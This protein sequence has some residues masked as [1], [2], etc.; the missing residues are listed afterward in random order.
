MFRAGIDM[1]QGQSLSTQ[2]KFLCQRVSV[3]CL[4]ECQMIVIFLLQHH[5]L[6]LFPLPTPYHRSRRIPGSNNHVLISLQPD[7]PP[8][9]SSHAHHTADAPYHRSRNGPLPSPLPQRLS[10]QHGPQTRSRAY[11]QRECQEEVPTPAYMPQ[12]P[13]E[14]WK[15]PEYLDTKKS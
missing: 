15:E 9:A 14:H 10:T 7:Q 12:V 1:S 8:T 5:S 13:P 4:E 11:H 3:S 2:N 6:Q